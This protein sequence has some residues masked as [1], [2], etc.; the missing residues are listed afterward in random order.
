MTGLQIDSVVSIYSGFDPLFQWNA[1]TGRIIF[2]D[3]TEVS[4]TK[5]IVPVNF[6]RVY[7]STLT[8]STICIAQF[9]ASVNSDYEETN[10]VIYNGCISVT[11][12]SHLYKSG[13]LSIVPNPSQGIFR[14]KSNSLQ[15]QMSQLSVVDVMGKV[16]MQ[17][18]EISL[19]ADGMEL[20]LS[21]LPSGMYLVNFKSEG[22]HV[23]ERL[24][25]E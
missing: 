17:E 22:I 20:D 3:T 16:V 6:L 5:Q 7:Y 11:G 18:R 2:V 19:G 9:N 23:I 21:H 10:K 8:S 1:S 4:L 14:L 13:I 15:G 25:I 12:N 24:V